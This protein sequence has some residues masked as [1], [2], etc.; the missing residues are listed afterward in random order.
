MNQTHNNSYQEQAET[1]KVIELLSIQDKLIKK[2]RINLYLP[3]AVVRLMDSLAKD[4][5]RG[6]LVSSLVIGEIKKQQK[7]PYGLFSPLQIT[8]KEINKVT[9]THSKTIDELT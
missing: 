7:M 5:S 3:E 2:T 1:E 8:E 9:K 6:E 4:K